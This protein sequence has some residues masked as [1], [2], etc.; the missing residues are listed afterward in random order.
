MQNLGFGVITLT[1]ILVYFGYV[2]SRV[3]KTKAEAIAL[4]NSVGRGDTEIMG[5]MKESV[6]SRLYCVLKLA[7]RVL[8]GSSVV[9]IQ[10]LDFDILT[11]ILV[12]L[13]LAVRIVYAI[14]IRPFA[15]VKNN[16]IEIIT[17]VTIFLLTSIH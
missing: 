16:V 10:N 15:L 6:S 14:S 7:L 5:M 9:L 4:D 3:Y 12:S 1:I 17:L 13:L 8:L 2:I 11:V